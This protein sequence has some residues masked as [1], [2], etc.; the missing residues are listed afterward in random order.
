MCIPRETGSASTSVGGRDPGD[1]G[2]EDEKGGNLKPCRATEGA[3]TAVDSAVGSPDE[4][5]VGP[6]GA[7]GKRPVG[8]GRRKGRGLLEQD[9]GREEACWSRTEEVSRQPSSNA[10]PRS[11]QSVVPMTSD[12][13]AS[14]ASGSWI[15]D[16]VFMRQFYTNFDV[17][18]NNNRWVNS[19]VRSVGIPADLFHHSSC[20]G[21]PGLQVYTP[22][23]STFR[24]PI[25][26]LPSLGRITAVLNAGDS[27]MFP[28]ST[29]RFVMSLSLVSQSRT[30]DCSKHVWL[31]LKSVAELSS[32]RYQ[33]VTSSCTSQLQGRGLL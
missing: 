12:P 19:N 23:S 14:F 7:G 5:E 1:R 28:G 4:R 22:E 15:L 21:A 29:H 33:R 16:E 27:G 2:Q 30:R 24:G 8:A 9:G 10:S 20:R 13:E 6:A 32:L 31:P 18:N 11:E 17:N 3:Q 26:R 25:W